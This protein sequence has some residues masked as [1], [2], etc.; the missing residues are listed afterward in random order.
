MIKVLQ[1][2]LSSNPGG[3]ESFVLN[4]NKYIKKDE[5]IFDYVDLYGEG[6]AFEK[7]IKLLDGSIYTVPNYKKH[8]IKAISILKKIVFNY[9][10]VHMQQILF[11]LLL[12]EATKNV[13][14]FAI[15]ILVQLLKVF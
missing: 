9:D 5:F 15:V 1:I 7:E 12:R 10:I 11:R 4:Y 8:P 6:I 3:V 13:L 14:L 2:G